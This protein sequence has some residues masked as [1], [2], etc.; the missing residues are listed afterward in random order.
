MIN[1]DSGFVSIPF[2]LLLIR[3]WN[4]KMLLRPS[5]TED[6]IFD[7]LS[8]ATLVWY[9]KTCKASYCQVQSY[10]CRRFRLHELLA[11]YFSLP[12]IDYL[13]QLQAATGM[14]ISGSTALQFFDR[15]IYPD[16]DLDL[17]VE[18]GHDFCEKIRGWLLEVGYTYIP[19][20]LS[21]NTSFIEDLTQI[22]ENH[23]EISLGIYW[24]RS[25]R[26]SL[27][28]TIRVHVFPKLGKRRLQSSDDCIGRTAFG[29][30]FEFSLKYIL[31]YLI[32]YHLH[33]ITY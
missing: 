22:Q 14:L 15:V 9:A 1:V 6:V 19:C 18:N 21:G 32:I 2:I 3:P 16:S 27:P 25:W 28:C 30:C 23:R 31:F 26:S 5:T 8:A 13:R 7:H 33:N 4:W 20:P 29:K 10:K 24:I 12:Q 17:Y 11:P